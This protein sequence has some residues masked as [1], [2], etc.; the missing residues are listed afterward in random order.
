[1]IQLGQVGEGVDGTG[2]A[3]VGRGVGDNVLS[4]PSV[5]ELP[6]VDNAVGSKVGRRVDG[7]GVGTLLGIDVCDGGADGSMNLDGGLEI[8]G[9]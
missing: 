6:N 2:N 1:M 4:E 9:A 5:S 3:S 8:V 7:R